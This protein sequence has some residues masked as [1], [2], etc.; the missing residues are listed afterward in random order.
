MN[1][2]NM[3]PEDIVTFWRDIGPKGW[4]EKNPKLDAEIR[5]RFLAVHEAAAGRL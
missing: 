3:R 5:Q 1:E 4:F 2:S